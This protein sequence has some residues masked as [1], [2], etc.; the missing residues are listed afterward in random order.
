MLISKQLMLIIIIRTVNN[1]DEKI[2]QIFV[3]FNW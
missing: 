3:N 1:D 2:M